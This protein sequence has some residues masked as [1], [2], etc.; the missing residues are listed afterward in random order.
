MQWTKNLVSVN[1]TSLYVSAPLP[2]IVGLVFLCVSLESLHAENWDRF[3]GP[4][5]EGQ[6]DASGIPSQWEDSNYLWKKPLPG[7]G[8][9][10]PVIWNDKL[11]L[12][13]AVPETGEQIVQVFDS[14]SGTPLWERRIVAPAVSPY[15]HHAHNSRASSTPAVDATHVYVTWLVEGKVMMAALRHNGDG[16]WRKEVGD[17]E[18]D[19]GFGGSPVVVDD[20]VCIANDSEAD[21]AI[22]ALDAQSGNVRWRVPRDPGTSSFATPC[23]FDPAAE[24][25]LLLTL[26]TASGLT[27]IDVKTG[28]VAWQAFQDDI[29]QRCVGSPVVA[30]GI[31]LMTC[32]QGGTGKWLIAAGSADGRQAP[33][34]LYRI[35][36]SAPYV[37]TPIIASD[38]LFLWHDRGIV[39]C[40]DLATGRQHWKERIGGDY[41]ASP[42]RIGDRIFGVS[43]QGEVVVLAADKQFSVLARNSLNEPCHATPAVAGNRLYVRTESTLYCIGEPVGAAAP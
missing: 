31:V 21:S 6:A 11:F 16:V 25:K 26:S 4:N 30:D 28:K 41:H 40:C 32:G 38:L 23:V 37:P 27:G 7:V 43:M 39:T 12:T 34:E 5:G 22:V 36:Q 2:K 35:E 14:L 19:H 3:R 17:Y 13:S 29:P 42:V 9:S 20:V 1:C 15:Q 10:S 24:Q 8:H 18:E 33:K